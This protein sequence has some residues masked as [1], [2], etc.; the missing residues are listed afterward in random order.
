MLLQLLPL[1]PQVHRQ[2]VV[3]IVEQ[4]LW[5]RK[6]ELLTPVQR[7]SYLLTRLLSLLR[8]I[9]N[10]RIPHILQKLYQPLYGIVLLFPHPSFIFRSVQGRVVR[11]RMIAHPIRH[12]L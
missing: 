5:P 10:V 9:R 3:H 4:R 7:L 1:L 12:E 6:L 8:F 2:L 11:C